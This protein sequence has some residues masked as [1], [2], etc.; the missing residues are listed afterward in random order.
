LSGKISL[1][2]FP[3]IEIGYKHSVNQY[4]SEKYNSKF[5]TYEPFVNL[6]Y[7]FQKKINIAF[8]YSYFIRKNKDISLS[9]S[10]NSGNL[11][12]DYKKEESPW[13]FKISALNL[14]NDSTKK[15]QSFNRYIISQSETYLMPRVLM[16]S[17]LYKL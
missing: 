6:N 17:V 15:Q 5:S 7:Y 1:N 14:L 12:I 8:N 2:N 3:V 9:D 10:Y 4:S 16:F 13:N 11:I